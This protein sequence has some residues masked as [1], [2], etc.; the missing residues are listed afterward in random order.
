MRLLFRTVVLLLVLGSTG[1]VAPLASLA[2]ACREDHAVPEG[3][4]DRSGHGDEGGG[5]QDCSPTCAICVCCPLRGA[6]TSAT[7]AVGMVP[8]TQSFSPDDTGPLLAGFATHI[9]HPPKA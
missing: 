5:C 2:E 9:F 1:V 3:P 7:V 8:R 6:G 4:L